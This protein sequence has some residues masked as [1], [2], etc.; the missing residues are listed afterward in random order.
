MWKSGWVDAVAYSQ[1]GLAKWSRQQ[2]KGNPAT[3]Q[4]ENISITPPPASWLLASVRGERDNLSAAAVHIWAKKNL[5]IFEYKARS[6]S[7]CGKRHH[8]YCLMLMLHNAISLSLS[9]S[10]DLLLRMNTLRTTTYGSRSS[11][12]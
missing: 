7:L 8:R 3:V 4:H 11:R 10:P 9:L 1:Q 5:L 6:S 12:E 2:K